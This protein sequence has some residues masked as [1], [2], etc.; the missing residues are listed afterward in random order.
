[1]P[2]FFFH[3]RTDT[4][5]AEDPEGAEFPTLE[6]A[7]TEAIAS[8]R[9]LTADALRQNLPAR[10]HHIDICDAAGRLL[11]TVSAQD[12]IGPLLP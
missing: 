10:N 6:A 12:A 7:R 5:L 8:L 3:S 4:A 9:Q 2:R 11:A 1:M